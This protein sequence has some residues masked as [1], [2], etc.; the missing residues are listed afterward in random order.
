MGCEIFEKNLKAMQKWYA[1]FADII[2]EKKFAE[3]P[4]AVAG[5]HKYQGVKAKNSPVKG[6]KYKPCHKSDVHAFLSPAHKAKRGDD[7]N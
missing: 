6:I 2:R 1:P 7:D 4:V 5:I 3:H